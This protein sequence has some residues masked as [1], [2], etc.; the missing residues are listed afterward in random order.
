MEPDTEHHIHDPALEEVRYHEDPKFMLAEEHGIDTEEPIHHHRHLHTDMN[1]GEES[2]E[3]GASEDEGSDADFDDYRRE[4]YDSDCEADLERKEEVWRA[5]KHFKEL[6][7]RYKHHMQM[8]DEPK[9]HGDDYWTHSE[10]PHHDEHSHHRKS[11]EADT[12]EEESHE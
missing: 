12:H 10:S 11:H 2:Y 4:C 5:K 9:H 3:A 7:Y 6:K 8:E 1:Q